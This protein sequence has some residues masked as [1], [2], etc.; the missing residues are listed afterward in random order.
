MAIIFEQLKSMVVFAQVVEQGSL[1]AAAKQL[2]LSR[3]VISY[4]L[5]K[6]EQ[7]LGVKL[8]NRSTRSL[9]LTEAG[10][11]YY[12]HC[13]KIA[14]QAAA[15]QLQIESLNQEPQ[16]MLKISCPVNAGLTS[17][18]PA[19]N[20][21][22]RLYPQIKLD[23]VLSDDV[24]NII[25]EGYD[26][27]I[28]GASLKDSGLQATKLATLKTCLCASSDYLNLH[29]RPQTPADLANHE[30]VIYSTASTTLRLTKGART[31]S[32]KMKGSVTTNNSAV[33]TTFVEGGHGIGRIPLYDALPKIKAGQLETILDD[34][35]S[36]EIDVYA[37][38]PPGTANSKKMRLVI[39]YIKNYVDNLIAEINAT[40]A[41]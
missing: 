18:V 33:R 35:H 23:L 9:H 20:Q 16:G 41:S 1:S 30:W 8:L 7:S 22:K 14:E 40:A 32:F 3:A 15:A 25:Q 31:F 4:H 10:E 11:Y 19:L 21:F 13:R 2:E 26:L 39:D 6:L 38:Y 24:V 29:G 37:V 34:Y 17:V 12:H 28:R 5:K 36:G 27:A